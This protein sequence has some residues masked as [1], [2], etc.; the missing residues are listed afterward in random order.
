MES[1][2]TYTHTAAHPT[3]RQFDEIIRK[4]NILKY[5]QIV[6]P[7]CGK[8][9]NLLSPKKISSNQ[10]LGNYFSK[11]VGFTKF[12]ISTPQC[13]NFGNSLSL[14]KSFVKSTL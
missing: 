5:F 1:T 10:L 12:I 8:I 2:Y 7:H 4:R 9:R 6:S 3:L 11:F 13:V 14:K